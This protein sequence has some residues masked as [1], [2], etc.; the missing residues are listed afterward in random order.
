MHPPQPQISVPHPRQGWAL[1][2]QGT[3]HYYQFLIPDLTIRHSIIVPYL[4]YFINRSKPEVSGTYGKG[5]PIYTHPLTTAQ[6]N[7]IS[8]AITTKQ[9]GLFNPN[10]SFTDAINH[11]MISPPL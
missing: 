2:T 1:N 3:T 9:H 7:Y 11:V 10:T 5:Y 8:P 4:L 6:V